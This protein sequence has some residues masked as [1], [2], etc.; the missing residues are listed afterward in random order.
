MKLL[1]LF[2]HP[3]LSRN[4]VEMFKFISIQVSQKWRINDALRCR[5]DYRKRQKKFYW[6]YLLIWRSLKVALNRQLS[7]RVLI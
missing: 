5:R 6:T 4:Y 3:N 2:P 1:L 7:L